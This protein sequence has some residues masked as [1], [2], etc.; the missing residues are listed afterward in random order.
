MRHC[1]IA[2][3]LLTTACV[4]FAAAQAPTRNANLSAAVNAADAKADTVADVYEASKDVWY[5]KHEMALT[6]DGS[7]PGNLRVF[8]SSGALV[9][10]RVKL[11]FIQEGQVVSQTLPNEQGDF[12]LSGLQPGV[13]SVVAAGQSGFGAIGVRILPPPNRPEAPKAN[14]IG[15]IREISQPLGMQFRMNI[16]LIPPNDVR[17]AFQLASQQNTGNLGGFPAFGSMGSGGG[18]GGGAGGGGLGPGLTRGLLG[19][20]L[21]GGI[22]GAVS[23]GSNDNNQASPN[24]S[25]S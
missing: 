20:L 7:V 8:D 4:E 13:Y 11:F 9:P 14:T 6:T 23:S 3:L 18:G 1:F 19:G 5:E 21:A 25:G 12:Q 17:T 22:I 16:S 24:G 2:V 15:K 10:A